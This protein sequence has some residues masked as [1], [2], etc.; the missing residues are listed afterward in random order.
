MMFLDNYP[1]SRRALRSLSMLYTHTMQQI[2]EM[3][4]AHTHFKLSYVLKYIMNR[5]AYKVWEQKRR[6]VKA[7]RGKL[8]SE[9]DP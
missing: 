6:T 8:K 5:E 7:K 4:P 9:T 3:Q 1:G 2:D